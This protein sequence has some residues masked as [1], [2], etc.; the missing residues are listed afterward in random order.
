MITNHSL[1]QK[2]FERWEIYY[3]GYE[4]NWCAE[5]AVTCNLSNLL[6]DYFMLLGCAEKALERLIRN[7]CDAII[8]TSMHPR[9]AITIV[10]QE[11]HNDGSV[12][13]ELSM[14]VSLEPCV[15]N[16]GY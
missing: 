11:L 3:F 15:F 2:K 7:T 16:R 8:L 10:V 14:H 13:F 12:S 1:F 6:H 4:Q 5:A 9:S